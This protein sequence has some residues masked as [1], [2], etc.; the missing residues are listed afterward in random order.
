MQ[1]GNDA[2]QPRPPHWLVLPRGAFED[3]NSVRRLV[4]V[5]FDPGRGRHGLFISVGP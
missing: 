3:A 4:R 1:R 2:I 5:G